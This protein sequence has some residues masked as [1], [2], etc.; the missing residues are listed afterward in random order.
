MAKK[1][2]PGS[3]RT[4]WTADPTPLPTVKVASSVPAGATAVAEFAFS[5]RLNRIPGMGKAA[6]QRRGFSGESGSLLVIDGGDESDS[7]AVRVVCGLGES[8]SV[9]PERMRSAIAAFTRSVAKHRR[10]AVDLLGDDLADLLGTD[11]TELVGLV[12]EAAILANYDYVQLRSSEDAGPRLNTVTVCASGDLRAMRSRVSRSSAVADAV[13]FARDMV[14]APGGTL[15][16]ERFAGVAAERAR[17]AGLSVEVLDEESIAQENLGGILAVNKG[18]SNP[19]RLVKL[20]YDPPEQGPP[21]GTVALVG[22]GI[23]FDSGG[24]SI[25]P[26]ESMI[27]MKMD[28]GGAAAV[29]AAM[30]CLPALE[31]PVR[32]VSFTPMTDNMTGPDAQRPGDVY[33]SRNGTTV[34]VL[35]TDAEGRLVLGEALVLASEEEPDAIVDLATLTGACM[36]ALGERIAGLMSNDDDLRDKVAEAAVRGGERVWALPLPTDYDRQLDSDIADVKNIGTRYGG[37]LTAG[38]FLQRFVGDGIPW[39]HLDIAGPAM[40]NSVDGVNPKGG[41]GFGVRT[42]CALLAGWTGAGPAEP[43]VAPGD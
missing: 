27:G 13:C 11:T 4:E 26:A 19:P 39:A 29:I 36:I 23:T 12:A 22:K 24:L 28:M 1:S 37:S 14:N 5:D 32:V 17:S 18:S 9:D 21:S 33:T 10:V 30:C 41:T 31:V 34:E 2:E 20:T 15:T 16:P 35:N 6:A 40:G 8:D 42:L 43:E 3:K 38:L 25:K 7:S